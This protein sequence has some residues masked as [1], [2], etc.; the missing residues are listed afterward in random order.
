MLSALG[1]LPHHVARQ[2]QRK[3]QRHRWSDKTN[4]LLNRTHKASAEDEVS[5]LI[6]WDEQLDHIGAVTTMS[7]LL[8]TH[9][10]SSEGLEVLDIV[11]MLASK[12]FASF[13]L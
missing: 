13:T 10:T 2:A 6:F 4:K 5:A 7:L 8:I 1:F 12:H 9:Q 3:G 11:A